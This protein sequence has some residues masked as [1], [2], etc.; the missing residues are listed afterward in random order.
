MCEIEIKSAYIKKLVY[1]ERKETIHVEEGEE[2]IHHHH[3]YIKDKH[4]ECKNG[5]KTGVQKD[6]M[7]HN[8]L[9]QRYVFLPLTCRILKRNHIF[10]PFLS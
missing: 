4:N 8:F 10:S 5:H 2:N 3:I 1:K 9:L 7:K 6:K